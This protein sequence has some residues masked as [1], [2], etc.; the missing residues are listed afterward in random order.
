MHFHH[1]FLLSLSAAA[2]A[3]S[4]TLAA[5]FTN[6]LTANASTRA[7]TLNRFDVV[8]LQHPID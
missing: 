1:V 7:G 8:I 6:V 2:G 5:S 4:A 3:Q